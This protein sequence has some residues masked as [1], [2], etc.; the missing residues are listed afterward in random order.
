M[1]KAW[2]LLALMA[3]LVAASD[4]SA[5]DGSQ[6]AWRSQL[7][8]GPAWKADVKPAG[9][10]A[11]TPPRDQQLRTKGVDAPVGSTSERDARAGAAKEA[12]RVRDA[13]RKK[14]D[15]DQQEQH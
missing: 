2:M 10:G 5:A 7:N 15:D 6:P 3:G 11:F 4:L 13:E 12:E 14:H 8:T 1:K 9:K